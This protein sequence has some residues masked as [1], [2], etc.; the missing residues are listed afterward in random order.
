M[1]RVQ[2]L[3]DLIEIHAEHAIYYGVGGLFGVGLGGTL[4]YYQG[5][6]GMFKPLGIILILVGLPLLGVAI[7]SMWKVKDVVGVVVTC[8]FC[9]AK[10]ELLAKPDEDFPCEGCARMIPIQDGEVMDV[11]QVR[12]GFCNELNYYSD[13]T[14]ALLCE[15]CNHEIPIAGSDDRPTKSIPKAYMVIDDESLY[16]LILTERGRKE[17]DLISAL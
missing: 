14:E 9:Q 10:N 11:H 3:S 7:N 2:R 17:E 6:S 15:E 13:K 16:E 1:P 4:I 8:P 5:Q 12:C